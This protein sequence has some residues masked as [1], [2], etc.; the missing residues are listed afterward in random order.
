[1]AGE[2]DYREVAAAIAATGMVA[3]GGFATGPDDG[4][5]MDDGS[6]VRCVVMVGNVGGV[7]WPYFAAER[8][9][10]T[11][12]L[13]DW[14]RTTLAPIASSFGA[15]FVHPSDEPFRPFQRWAERADD[16]W[17]SPIG[18]LI[19]ADHGLW[20]AYRGALLFSES[21]TGLPAVGTAVS[22]CVSCVEQPCLRACPVDAFTSE[23]YDS[24][25]CGSHVRSGAEPDCLHRGCA[26]R[27]ACPI[28]TG[29]VYGA[30][31]MLFHMQAFVG[32]GT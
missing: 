4:L 18:L 21:V 26:A 19:H 25:T 29:S 17:Q 22:P 28:G 6:P 30:E 8:R 10:G 12:P 7:M 23:G 24:A 20:H 3:R 31:Q 32:T 27:L 13:D 1:M 15:S 14:T 16:V 9:R 2:L 11:H 5:T